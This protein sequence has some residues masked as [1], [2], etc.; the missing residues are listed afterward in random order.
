MAG[1]RT[2]AWF[3]GVEVPD[4]DRAVVAGGGEQW[5]A[6]WPPDQ[7]QRANWAVMRLD[8]RPR[9]LAWTNGHDADGAV[10]SRNRDPSGLTGQWAHG[11][12]GSAADSSR[13]AQGIA[14][15]HIGDMHEAGDVTGDQR[16]LVGAG[17]NAAVAAV[18]AFTLPL[19]VTAMQSWP[20]VAQAARLVTVSGEE[21]S[22]PP[23]GRPVAGSQIR[24]VLSAPPV[25]RRR[26]PSS[27]P[28]S[29]HTPQTTPV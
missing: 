4:P 6:V 8:H 22:G 12:D 21:E 28:R 24:T 2:A 20:G 26:R 29:V 11:E 16:G 27:S 14:G 23:T 19:L 9:V 13:C 10:A 3:P 7:A 18:Q 1:E 5:R 15:G 25:A 17:L